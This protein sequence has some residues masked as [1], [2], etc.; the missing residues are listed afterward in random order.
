MGPLR[1]SVRHS[2]RAALS[3][4]MPSLGRARARADASSTTA[5]VPRN[6]TSRP[7]S[8]GPPGTGPSPRHCCTRSSATGKIS[9]EAR[10]PT[11]P[12]ERAKP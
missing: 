11:V 2:P 5:A 12:Q 7:G 3:D 9:T 8:E 1:S 6:M 4:T 10:K